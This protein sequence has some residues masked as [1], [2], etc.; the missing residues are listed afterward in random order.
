MNN[1]EEIK[2]EILILAKNF[3]IFKKCNE[4]DTLEQELKVLLKNL[5]NIK[6]EVLNE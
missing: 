1:E 6:I 3:H 5:K 4:V 2:K